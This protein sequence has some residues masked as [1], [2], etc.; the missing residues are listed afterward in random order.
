MLQEYPTAIAARGARDRVGDVSPWRLGDH[1]QMGFPMASTSTC[2]PF[3]SY[4][5]HQPGT[6]Y[7]LGSG[8][9]SPGMSANGAGYI[10]RRGFGEL[11]QNKAIT[12]KLASVVHYQQVRPAVFWLCASLALVCDAHAATNSGGVVELACAELRGWCGPGA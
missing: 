4:Y 8:A 7:Q 6:G 5:L 10:S 11:N 9:T 12:K 2:S 3:T 1:G